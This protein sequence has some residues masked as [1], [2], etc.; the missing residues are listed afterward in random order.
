MKGKAFFFNK[1]ISSIDYVMLYHWKYLSSFL[2]L[3]I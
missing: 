3:R 1:D 2:S